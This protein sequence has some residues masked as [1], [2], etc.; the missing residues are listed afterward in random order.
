MAA[1][2]PALWPWSLFAALIAAAGLPIYINAPKFYAEAHGVPLAALGLT[3]AA[4]RLVDVVQDP[5]LGW[6][7]EARR[8]SRG[9]LVW[10][11]SAVMAL[12]MAGL[13][14][15]SPPIAP[16]WWFAAMMV[17]LFSA[18]SFLTIVLYAQG[19][20]HSTAMGPGGHLR[21]AGWR[22]TGGLVGVCAAAIA[23]TLLAGVT[24]RPMTGFALGFAALALIAALAMRGNWRAPLPRHRPAAPGIAAMLRPIWGD[25]IARRLVILALINSAPVA[26][27]STL[28]LFYVESV[29]GLAALS[30]LFLLAF[31][32]SA[33][34]S[35]P[36]WARLGRRIGEKRV[37]AAGMTLSILT[38]FWASFLG[39]GQ[40]VAFGAISAL[41]GAALGADMVLLPALFARRLAEIGDASEG[42]GF[43]LWSFVSKL[44]L[45]FAAA[46]LLPALQGAGF[47]QA[48]ASSPESLR[49]LA[50][51]YAALPCALKLLSLGLLWPL[52]IEKA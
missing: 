40:A 1:R 4:L 34:L 48:G 21:L 50:L 30:G 2:Q 45:A 9:A 33:A 5:L 7:A 6:L 25:P 42:F 28:L 15:V 16:L 22:E 13:F 31:F 39:P 29:L 36:L 35:A 14:A 27:T 37:L 17:C 20:E 41:S 38:F 10:G 46:L 24:D 26:I 8:A 11:A 19:V 43:G 18:Y 23:P 47:S 32:L 44:C 51:L 52:P 3:L 12:S 49:L